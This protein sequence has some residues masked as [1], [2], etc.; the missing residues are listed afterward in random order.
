M[1]WTTGA[2]MRMGKTV[3]AAMGLALVLGLS[4]AMVGSAVAD[5]TNDPPKISV[6]TQAACNA[7][8]TQSASWLITNGRDKLAEITDLTSTI[9]PITGAAIGTTIPA[10][11]SVTATL[12]TAGTTTGTVHLEVELS[13]VGSDRERSSNDDVTFVGGCVATPPVTVTVPG[14]TVTVPGPTVFVQTP[15]AP[16]PV[17]AAAKFTG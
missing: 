1:T 5:Q 17:V 4:A 3:R 2:E 8:G 16:A 13:W 15:A 10:G 11:G 9:G 6:E 14:P 12:V 7:D